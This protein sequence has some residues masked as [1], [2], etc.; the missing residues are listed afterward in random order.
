MGACRAQAQAALPTMMSELDGCLRAD[1]TWVG[2]GEREGESFHVCFLLP[3][4][5]GGQ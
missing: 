2:S 5:G 4:A 3:N 1:M